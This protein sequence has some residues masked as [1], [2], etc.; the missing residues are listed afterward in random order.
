L[1]A[2]VGTFHVISR[3]HSVRTHS[4]QGDTVHATV[5]AYISYIYN[6]LAIEYPSHRTEYG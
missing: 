6:N 4:V 5:S 2:A 3:V 1:G